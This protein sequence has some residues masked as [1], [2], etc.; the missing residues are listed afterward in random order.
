MY[1]RNIV[2]KY[3]IWIHLAKNP[4][5]LQVSLQKQGQFPINFKT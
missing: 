1:A 2:H 5:D 3:I 4:G